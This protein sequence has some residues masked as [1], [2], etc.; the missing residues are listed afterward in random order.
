MGASADDAEKLRALA[1]EK[2]ETCPTSSP[3]PAA[4]QAGAGRRNRWTL[5]R[6]RVFAG[7]YRNR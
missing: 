7:T 3:G 5:H 2:G 4:G 1:A 6:V